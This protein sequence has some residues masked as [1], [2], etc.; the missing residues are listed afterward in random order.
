[1]IF[2][3]NLH[4]PGLPL[5]MLVHLTFT[6]PL[7]NFLYTKSDGSLIIAL[8]VLL[9]AKAVRGHTCIVGGLLK[10]SYTIRMQI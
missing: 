3:F 8:E 9:E 5:A 2:P 6:L 10:E 1:M 4:T 7:L